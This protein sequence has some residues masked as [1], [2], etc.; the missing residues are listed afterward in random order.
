M[1][2]YYEKTT[3]E[4]R[5]KEKKYIYKW[6]QTKTEKINRQYLTVKQKI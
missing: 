1:C 2:V 6:K 4:N 5:D 3:S